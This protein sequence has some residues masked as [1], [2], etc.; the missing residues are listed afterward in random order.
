MIEIT[1]YG[2]GGQGGVTLAKLIATMFFLKGKDVQA[3]GVYA[4]ERSGAPIQAFVRIDDEEITNNNQIQQP[5]H[6]IVLDRTLIA[7]RV[8]TGLKKEGWALLNTPERATAY[9]DLFSGRPVAVLD[10]T[11]I[12]VEHGL[13]TK[14]LPIV[15]TTILGGMA[16][17]L[18]LSVEDAEG[19][20]SELGFGGS[21]MDVVREA[22]AGISAGRLPGKATETTTPTV[23]GT[24]ASL[25]SGETSPMPKILTGDW[26]NRAPDYRMLT[27][28]CN[29]GCPAGNDVRGFIAAM[30]EEDFTGALD[31][32]MKT[33][34]LPATCGRVCPAPCMDV[35]SRAEHDESVN[36]RELERSAATLGKRPKP[37]KPHRPE[38]I[39]VVGSGPA[40]LSAAYHAAKLGYRV[41]LYEGAD[42]LG[43]VMRTGI[44]SY[45]LPPDVLDEEIDHI[46][47]HGVTVKTGQFIDKAAMLKMS[48]AFDAVVVGAGLQSLRAFDLGPESNGLVLQGIEFLD[49]ARHGGMT[50]EGI[51]IVVVG[52]GNTAFDAARTA[53]RLGAAGVK[54]IYRR[55]R[56]EM[57]A[58]REEIEEGIDEGIEIQELVSPVR[59]GL[60]A[61]RSVL[62][63]ARMQLGEP[64]ESGRPRPVP[65]VG[66]DAQFEMRADRVILA[67]GQSADRSILPEGA[68]V[69]DGQ[70]LL[71]TTG[72]PVYFCGDFA[73]NEGTVTAAIGGGRTA[74]LYVHRELSGEDLLPA[75]PPRVT[76]QADLMTFVFKPQQRHEGHILPGDT[77]ATSFHEVRQ[78]FQASSGGQGDAIAEA[79]RCFS[80]GVCTHCDRCIQHC[81][82]GVVFRR[83]EGYDFDFDYCKGCGIC[84]AE[85][86]RGVIGMA[87]LKAGMTREAVDG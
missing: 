42:E 18:G 5:D 31:I 47:A 3:F 68:E 60:G 56:N 34:P 48:Q 67:L 10:A 13:G 78:G 71:G 7:P 4:A 33:S 83:G 70:R 36:I 82:E 27:P 44:P 59:L 57:P 55:T 30:A 49:Q 53:L 20:I 50:F 54:M 19:A 1:I 52:G 74:S 69:R 45:R 63:C 85:C 11:A 86:P 51:E 62:T 43:G 84:S 32:L 6:I 40:G 58:I 81:P 23:K 37:T 61:D 15:N 14:A 24:A 28:P 22:Y 26:T 77:R 72:A 8:L 35:C 21:N 9:A 65:V 75:Q 17:I 38:E 66:A 80:C 76:T 64:D 73:D 79:L 12:A 46:L 29:D 41:T 39:A 87:D 25:I 2:R 16:K